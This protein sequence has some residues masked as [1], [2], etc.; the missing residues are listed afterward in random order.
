MR[1]ER[2][3]QKK[4]ARNKKRREHHNKV[5]DQRLRC[6]RGNRFANQK[7]QNYIDHFN[8]LKNGMGL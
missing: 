1:N 4:L 8:K 3:R 2:R 6:E 7:E 5:Y